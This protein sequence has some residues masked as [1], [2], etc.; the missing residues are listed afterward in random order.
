V[1]ESTIEE[2]YV[3]LLDM[4]IIL[5]FIPFLYMFAAL[6]VLRIKA[7]GNN[8]GVSLVPGGSAGV[9]LCS[10]LGFGATLL[11]VVLAIL[12][13]AGTS[14]PQMFVIKVGGGCLLFVAAG[15]LFYYR[16]RGQSPALTPD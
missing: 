13:P 3:M 7:A 14:N 2:A 8:D 11:S 9:W 15:L 5:Y 10:A 12:P 16:N 1:T 6:P 4:T